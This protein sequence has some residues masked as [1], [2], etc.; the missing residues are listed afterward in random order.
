M[1]Y[2]SKGNAYFKK[3][4]FKKSISCYTRSIALDPT[5]VAVP[6]NRA[7]AHLKLKKYCNYYNESFA[8]LRKFSWKKAEDD[9]TIGLSLEQKNVKA[10]WRR[11]IARRELSKYTEAKYG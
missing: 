1:T 3:G 6:I 2:I 5:S 4:E 9:C 10:L 11:G 7:M 8:Y